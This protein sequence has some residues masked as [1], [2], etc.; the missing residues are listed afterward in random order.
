ML[1]PYTDV[2]MGYQSDTLVAW[3]SKRPQSTVISF[4]LC[5]HVC[6]PCACLISS[7]TKRGY[8]SLYTVAMSLP[9][10]YNCFSFGNVL[11]IKYFHDTEK[12]G[13]E[14][15]KYPL[16]SSFCKCSQC[17]FSTTSHLFHVTEVI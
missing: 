12:S 2:I 17:F 14:E 11:V 3:Y 7:E 5:T 10:T 1:S 15:S 9:L 13:K 6:T 16:L 8:W 4:I